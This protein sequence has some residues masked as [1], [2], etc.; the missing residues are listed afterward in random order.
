MHFNAWLQ[1]VASMRGFNAWLQCVVLQPTSKT[2]FNTFAPI[3]QLFCRPRVFSLAHTVR[4]STLYAALYEDIALNKSLLLLALAPST[5]LPLAGCSHHNAPVMMAPPA[6]MVSAPQS[7]VQVYSW[8]EVPVGQQ[9][10]I[11]RAVFDGGGYQLSSQEGTI[12]VPFANQNMYVMKFG[13]SPNGTEY[14]VN[15]GS[16]PTLYLPSSGYLDNAG[17]NGAR[18]YPFPQNYNY[19]GPVYVGLAPS[20]SA[21]QGMGWYPGMSSYGGYYGYSPLSII[22]PMVGLHFLIG[23]SPYYGWN[24]YHSYYNSHP[25]QRVAPRVVS[26]TVYNQA[27]RTSFNRGTSLGSGRRFGSAGTAS[28]GR[29]GGGFGSRPSGGSFGSRTPS[30][31]RGTNRATSGSFGRSPSGFGGS[32]GAGRPSVSAPASSAPTGSFGSG[33][34]T[35][36]GNGSFGSGSSAPSSRPS[37]GGFGGGHSSFGGHPFGGGHS[38]FGG[39]RRR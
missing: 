39:G 8:T 25:Y 22:G 31:Y 13:Q 5:L 1:C 12:V 33:R 10:P 26:R 14:F 35:S 3:L 7:G 11:K 17:Q 19:N 9:V 2:N 20:W 34:P 6:Q 29:P 30:G 37:F 23:G 21:Y 15:N 18:W 24:S 4:H 28:S 32:F 36:S 16:V 38:S 27:A